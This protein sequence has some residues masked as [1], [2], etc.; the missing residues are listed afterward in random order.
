MQNERKQMKD[1]EENTEE[2]GERT[3]I[4]HKKINVGIQ[5]LIM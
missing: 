1:E 5:I 4:K 2:S 3:Q